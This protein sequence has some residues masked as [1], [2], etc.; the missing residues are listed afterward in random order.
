MEVHDEREGPP[1]ARSRDAAM[2]CERCD[3]E[4]RPVT[5]AKLAEDG[6]RAAI[7][8]EVPMDECPSCGA[9]WLT[10]EVAQRLDEMLAAR[11]G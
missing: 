2:T 7:V 5:G 10:C 6:G 8:L 11:Y 4:R 9:R 3:Q 1:S